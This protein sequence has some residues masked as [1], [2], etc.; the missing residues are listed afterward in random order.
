MCKGVFRLY[1][2][3]QL[4]IVSIKVEGNFY[5]CLEPAGVNILN[6]LKM[7]LGG[8]WWSNSGFCLSDGGEPSDI[9]QTGTE[10]GLCVV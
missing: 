2:D 7:D 3:V 4:C 10:C 9:V 1:C 8:W 5:E 6:I